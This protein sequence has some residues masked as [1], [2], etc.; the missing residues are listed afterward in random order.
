MQPIRLGCNQEC[1]IGAR[2]AKLWALRCIVI[3]RRR[4]IYRILSPLLFSCARWRLLSGRSGAHVNFRT[5][6]SNHNGHKTQCFRI[7]RCIETRINRPILPSVLC[8]PDQIVY[9]VMVRTVLSVPFRARELSFVEC[10]TSTP[11]TVRFM[12]LRSS[13]VAVSAPRAVSRRDENRLMKWP[14][15]LLLGI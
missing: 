4:I 15:E 1:F 10:V 7:R 12:A 11:V 9:C 6:I 14:F 2:Y 3:D 13:P 8:G 5:R